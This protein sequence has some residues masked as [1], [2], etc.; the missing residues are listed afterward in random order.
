[1]ECTWQL[2]G[3]AEGRQVKDA[4]IAMSHNV[5]GSGATAVIHIYKNL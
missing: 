4:H 1:V 3:E 5:G 2:R